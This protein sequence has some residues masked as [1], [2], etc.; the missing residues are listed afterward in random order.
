[1]RMKMKQSSI[2]LL[3]LQYL[4]ACGGTEVGNGRSAPERPE[5]G[6]QSNNAPESEGGVDAGADS[7]STDPLQSGAPNLN[8]IDYLFAKCASPFAIL[9]PGR[10]E[11]SD[12]SEA[13]TF[14]L[15]SAP[16]YTVTI[17]STISEITRNSSASNP[18]AI[19]TSHAGS[20]L[21]CE[22]TSVASSLVTVTFSNSATLSWTISAGEVSEISL[23]D[24]SG[25]ILR[26]Y[27]R[28]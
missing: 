23:K 20:T 18:Y 2:L 5:T 17:G 13:F 7:P 11:T 14:A 21:A 16:V 22:S 8:P 24:A 12:G 26:T 25:T 9:N 1:M 19:D 15:K 28:Q 3:G 6:K 27:T 10:Y 4:L